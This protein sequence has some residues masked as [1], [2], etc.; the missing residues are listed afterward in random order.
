MNEMHNILMNINKQLS[1]ANGVLAAVARERA[2]DASSFQR[3]AE[4]RQ[5]T[6]YALA[7]TVRQQDENNRRLTEAYLM[8]A[9]EIL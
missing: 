8:L 5:R 1:D 7:E 9:E 2:A 6:I 4:E 3:L